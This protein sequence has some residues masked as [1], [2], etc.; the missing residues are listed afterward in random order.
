MRSQLPQPE[1]RQPL[2]GGESQSGS[3]R[4]DEDTLSTSTA[5]PNIQV[6]AASADRGLKSTR[7]A[8]SFLACVPSLNDP[9]CP[10]LSC[11][12]CAKP[13]CAGTRENQMKPWSSEE[14][15]AG[16][17]TQLMGSCVPALKIWI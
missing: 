13:G 16:R 4:A 8:G 10:Y 7:I 2:A 14:R 3:V 5:K 6:V 17:E 1:Q 12:S 11:L 9:R 15:S